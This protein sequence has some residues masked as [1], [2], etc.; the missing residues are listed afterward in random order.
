MNPDQ[1]VEASSETE[2]RLGAVDCEHHRNAEQV[3]FR[4]IPNIIPTPPE[5]DSILND[6]DVDLRRWE[7]LQRK[8]DLA[9]VY[10]VNLKL[11]LKFHLRERDR[12]KNTRRKKGEEDMFIHVFAFPLFRMVSAYWA[13]L[14]VRRSFDLDLLEWRSINCMRSSTIEEIK[15]RRVA[16]TRHQ[17][18]IATSLEILRGLMV[19][20]KG[21][22]RMHRESHPGY[23]VGRA[24]GLVPD[25]AHEDSWES[26]YWDFYE[27]QSSMDALEKRAAKIHDGIIGLISVSRTEK[28]DESNRSTRGFNIIAWVFAVIFLPFQIVPPIFETSWSSGYGPPKTIPQYLWAIFGTFMVVTTVWVILVWVINVSHPEPGEQH[29]LCNWRL[30]PVRKI[31]DDRDNLA[32]QNERGNTTGV[33]QGAGNWLNHMRHLGTQKENDVETGGS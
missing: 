7:E 21:E 30:T 25:A 28:A 9:S 29:R 10:N 11:H 23:N 4:S 26:V 12:V 18:D 15:S 24:N 27:L 2:S 13:R 22:P 1:Q 33:S 8:Q 20:E 19:V 14:V 32:T 3:R 31:K 16:I 17:R 6:D 5:L